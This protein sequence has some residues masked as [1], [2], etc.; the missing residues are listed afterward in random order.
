MLI[1]HTNDLAGRAGLSVPQHLPELHIT[2]ER[3]WRPADDPGP[4]GYATE[5]CGASRQAIGSDSQL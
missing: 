2:V 5:R 3:D 4:W 1:A